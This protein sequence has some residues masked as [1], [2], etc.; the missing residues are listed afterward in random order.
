MLRIEEGDVV[1]RLRVEVRAELAVDHREDVAVERG[2]H[3][4]R[5]VVGGFEDSDVLDEV[6]PEQEVVVGPE[7][8]GEV[9][10]E[11]AARA[12]Q[13]V[14][15]R[16]AEEGDDPGD[17][18]R[19]GRDPVQ[20]ALEVADD[21]VDFEAGIGGEELFRAG[22]DDGAVDVEG[23]VAA[24]RPRVARLYAGVGVVR[25]SDPAAELA[26]TEVKLGALLPVLSG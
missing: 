11:G 1:E 23:D 25:D 22:T 4:G 10:Q 2:R 5:V 14:A 26:E 16:A 13:E 20:V 17:P 21:P 3:P 24:Q 15:D 7:R 9:A 6:R 19:R 8:R 18:G 12:R